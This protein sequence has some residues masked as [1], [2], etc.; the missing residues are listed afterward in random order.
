M[1]SGAQVFT[2]SASPFCLL[3]NCVPPSVF[4]QEFSLCSLTMKRAL[5]RLAS[6]KVPAMVQPSEV[7]F[8]VFKVYID[9]KMFAWVVMDRPGK[10]VNGD[11]WKKEQKKIY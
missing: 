2:D 10:S 3:L 4:L 7:D 6:F 1:F 8:G 5:F 9:G 11:I